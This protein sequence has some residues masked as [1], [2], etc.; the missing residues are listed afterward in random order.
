MSY[1]NVEIAQ[2][3]LEHFRR[4][5]EPQ[6]ETVDPAIEVYD[7]DIPDAGSYRG[8]EGYAR[9][10]PIQPRP[11]KPWARRSSVSQENV[12]IVRRGRGLRERRREDVARCCRSPN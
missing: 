1:E 7:H 4:T 11:S 2:Q 9:W 12:E 6:W 10:P 8:H 5:G 3:G